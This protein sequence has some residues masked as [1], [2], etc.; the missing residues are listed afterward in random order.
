M[1]EASLVRLLGE[2]ARRMGVAVHRTTDWGKAPD[3]CWVA[4]L[5]ESEI[6]QADS[7]ASRED[8][9][10]GMRGAFAGYLVG[11]GAGDAE[12][13]RR[14]KHS[15]TAFGGLEIMPPDGVNDTLNLYMWLGFD[16]LVDE[17]QS[18]EV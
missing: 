13:N 4:S 3:R 12:R 1:S 2:P 16:G 10:M 18:R 17:S 11:K 14:L 9:R 15:V 8:V 6:P 5:G 7:P